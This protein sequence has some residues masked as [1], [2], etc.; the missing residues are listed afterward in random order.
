MSVPQFSVVVP[1]RD[2][3]ALLAQCLEQLA[4]GVQSTAIAYE[5]IVTDDSAVYSAE[6]FVRQQFPWVRVVQG[7]RRGPAANRNAGARV[8]SGDLLVFLDD[9]CIPETTLLAGYASALRLGVSAYEGRITCHQGIASPLTTAPVNL[10]GGT[11]WS[12]NFAIRRDA[13]DAVGGFDE[14]F[15]TAHMEDADLR[16]RL[17]HAG[18]TIEFV[19]GASVDHPPRQLAWGAKLAAMHRA[20]VLYMTLHPPVRSYA[21][22]F[23]NLLRARVSRVVHLPLSLD[24]LA[25]LASVPV[26][27]AVS[28]WH[29]REWHRWARLVARQG[30]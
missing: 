30:A 25:A 19:P 2:R 29:W 11:L 12:C 9:D 26:E 15:P 17:L 24:S 5:V 10:T 13:F 14:R 7:P 4:P 23:Q 8:A 21:W 22:F 16:D 3:N 28:A 18:H 20:T 1:T 27:L 6:P